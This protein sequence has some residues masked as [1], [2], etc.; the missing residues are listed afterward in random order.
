MKKAL[1][2]CMVLTVTISFACAGN[3]YKGFEKKEIAL[4]LRTYPNFND[5]QY[6][7]AGYAISKRMELSAGFLNES[8]YNSRYTID[9]EVSYHFFPCKKYDLYFGIGPSYQRRRELHVFY[10]EESD[11][12]RFSTLHDFYG[13]VASLGMNYWIF[14]NGSI[15]FELSPYLLADFRSINNNFRMVAF[16][17]PF[18][19]LKLVF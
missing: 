2:L 10:T 4:G 6:F 8:S 14:R 12:I 7:Y 15:G 16:S 5:G 3:L 13:G 17:R 19:G 18:L 1:L 11:T 9:A